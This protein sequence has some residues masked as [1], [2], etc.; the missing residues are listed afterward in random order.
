MPTREKNSANVRGEI[1]DKRFNLLT[2]SSFHCRYL[3]SNKLSDIPPDVFSELR[4]LK[5]V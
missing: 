3:D 2:F 5:Y 4:N 1:A